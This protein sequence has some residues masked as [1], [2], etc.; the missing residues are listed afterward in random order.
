VTVGM[1]RK[2]K[3]QRKLEQEDDMMFFGPTWIIIKTSIAHH[4]SPPS[5]SC[6]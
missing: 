3:M 6:T 4:D 2:R 1:R 5:L